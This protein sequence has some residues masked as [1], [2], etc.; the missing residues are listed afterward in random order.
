MFI[1]V[2]KGQKH[3]DIHRENEIEGKEHDIYNL[4]GKV[5]FKSQRKH[6]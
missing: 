4:T 6:T 3:K 2:S 5:K 1:M